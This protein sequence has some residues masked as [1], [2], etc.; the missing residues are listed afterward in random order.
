MLITGCTAKEE[1]Q[2]S[3]HSHDD[4]K[5]QLTTYSENFEVFMV[6]DPFIVNK[7]T[8]I[9]AHITSLNDF[10][11]LENG[12]VTLHL[13]VKDNEISQ[14]L[15]N[16][17]GKGL[18]DF[19]IVPAKIGKG[20]II[21]DIRTGDVDYQVKVPDFKVFYDAHKAI[22]AA[23]EEEELSTVNASTFTKEQSWKIDFAT[24]P[25]QQSVFGPVIKTTAQVQSA[26]GDEVLVTSRTNGIIKLSSENILEG[27]SVSVGQELFSISGSGLA[28]DN[29]AVRYMEAKNRFDQA[30]MDYE[31]ALTL[32][33]DK[34]VSEK[35]LLAAR[36]EFE[37]AKVIYESLSENFNAAGENIK[38]PMN[39]FVKQLFVQNGQYVEAGQAIV[40]VSQNRKLVLRAE[41][42][43]KYANVLGTI[44]TANI[45]TLYDDQSYTLEQLNGK[46]LSYGRS[47][48]DGN[49]QIPVSLEIDNVGHFVPGSFAEVYLKIQTNEYSLTVPNSALLEEQGVFFV[50]VQI[51]PELFEKREVLPGSTDGIRTEILNGITV[52]ERIVSKGAVLIKLSQATGTLDAHSGHVH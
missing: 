30:S 12:S 8:R 22:H 14:T 52:N 34:I 13:I 16:P 21:F 20:Q 29:S 27:K 18:Y 36:S 31:R 26:Q 4:V 3:G 40:N 28:D 38:S 32:S 15:D 6:A 50:F 43:Q 35:D 49:Y 48:N 17:S 24:E 25:V 45:R 39:G 37:N 51:T 41:V 19:A 7:K 1:K 33:K 44:K 9:L 10:K 47:A 2:S 46:V 11:P 5:I 23:E 42:Q